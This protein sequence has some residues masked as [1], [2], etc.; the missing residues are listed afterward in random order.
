MTRM[1]RHTSVSKKYSWKAK[2]LKKWYAVY[3]Q[4][5]PG[6]LANHPRG[7]ENRLTLVRVFPHEETQHDDDEDNENADAFER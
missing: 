7:G 2:T 3:S 6:P 4:A 5:N 1:V